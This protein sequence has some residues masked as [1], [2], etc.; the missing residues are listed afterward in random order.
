MLDAILGE[1]PSL[2]N[3]NASR[4]MARFGIHATN[5]IGLSVPQLRSIARRVGRELFCVA[6]QSRSA[7]GSAQPAYTMRAFS[8]VLNCIN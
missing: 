7:S 3:P 6:A 5:V 1:M 8:L 2:G 4:E